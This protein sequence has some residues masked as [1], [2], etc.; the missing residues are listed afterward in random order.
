MLNEEEPELWLPERVDEVY[1]FSLDVPLHLIS[2]I[3]LRT[4]IHLP[5]S[6]V[7]FI[8]TPSS[9]PPTFFWSSQDYY[10]TINPPP[11]PAV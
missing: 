5:Q 4:Y 2:S 11:L 7:D 9:R 3:A 1:N 8:Y 6:L 10:F